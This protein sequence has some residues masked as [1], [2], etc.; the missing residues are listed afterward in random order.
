MRLASY[1]GI[2]PV[3][4]GLALSGN[5]QLCQ[6][7]KEMRA[8]FQNLGLA[9]G[10]QDAAP[11][12]WFLGPEWFMPP[13]APVY[14]AKVVSGASCNGGRQC[15]T[16]HS[17]RDDPSV[18]M[19]FFYQVVDAAQYRGKRLTYRADVRA[20]VAP[21]SVARL[22][23]RVHRTD[24]STSFRDDMGNKPI[25]AGTWSPY[26]IQAP[27]ALDAR[28]IEFGMQ[29]FGQGAAWIDNISMTFADAVR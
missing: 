24:C 13:H 12:G 5:A 9:E 3:A 18:R 22:L 19:C 16:V 17:I 25:T 23:V 8:V 2:V 7:P 29:V 4:V 11:P 28:D 27:I 21:G 15:A 1:I 10:T 6:P 20:D 26:E 14:E